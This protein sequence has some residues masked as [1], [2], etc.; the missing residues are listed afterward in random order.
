MG[1]EPS[2][3][4]PAG[5]P[6]ISSGGTAGG[7]ELRRAP[8]DLDYPGGG[9]QT[10]GGAARAS[11]GRGHFR[12]GRTASTGQLALR[13]TWPDTLPRTSRLMATLGRRV[14]T[15]TSARQADASRAI[16]AATSPRGAS[17]MAVVALGPPHAL[18][19]TTPPPRPTAA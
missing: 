9:R 12:L 19:G 18:T 2:V 17:T 11:W 13:I 7:Q 16:A 1:A 10:P 14:T 15:I 8:E 4:R 3:R 6:L 5:D